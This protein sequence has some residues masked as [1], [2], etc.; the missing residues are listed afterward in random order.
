[1]QDQAT[2]PE[3]TAVVLSRQLRD[4]TVGILGTRSEVAAAGCALAQLTSAP[5]L[6]FLSGP[7]GVVNPKP[8]R[9]LPIADEA[10]IDG[11]EALTEL[12]DNIDL[13]DWS[14]RAF[15]FAVLGGIQVD[16]FGNLN[17][18]A[19]GDWAKPK[20]RG[21]GAIGAS[22]LA[23]HA[24]EFFIVMGEHSTRNF[25][26]EVDFVSALGFGRTGTERDALGLPGGGP[27][28]LISPLGTFDFGGHGHTM[29][30]RTVHPWSS[31]EEITR[32]TGF[33]LAHHED[34]QTTPVPRPEEL[35]LLRAAVDSTGVLR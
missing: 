31:V 33:E 20:V 26:P 28:L 24:G 27:S 32:N 3:F 5:G 6:S 17:T 11:A 4:D 23:G 35:E 1:M 2:M 8:G 14:R 22:V 15:D 30:V 13:I 16:R 34:I 12:S 7:S 9:L 21:P 19:V 29:R 18:V 25:R 10:L